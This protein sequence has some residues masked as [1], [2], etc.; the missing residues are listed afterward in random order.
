MYVIERDIQY[1]G[2]LTA[3]Q[4]KDISKTSC[5]VLNELG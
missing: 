5:D 1:T 3:T 4:L 2:K